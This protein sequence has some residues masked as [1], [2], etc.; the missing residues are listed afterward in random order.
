MLSSSVGSAAVVE[1]ADETRRFVAALAI[2]LRET[3]AAF[4]DTVAQI[5]EMAVL[6]HGSNADREL[7]VALQQFDRLHQEFATLSDVLARLSGA[8]HSAGPASAPCS[9]PDLVP[10]IALAGLRDR[11]TRHLS[12]TDDLELAERPDD[13]VF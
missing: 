11:L 5:T 7:V 12:G 4:E 3:V 8:P 10:A 9:G 13:A 1:T 2:V 6:R